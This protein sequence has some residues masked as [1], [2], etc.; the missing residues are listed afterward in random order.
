MRQAPSIDGSLEFCY[1]ARSSGHKRW[2]RLSNEGLKRA[3][4]SWLLYSVLRFFTFWRW[5]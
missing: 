1:W 3:P 4:V 5:F 2:I